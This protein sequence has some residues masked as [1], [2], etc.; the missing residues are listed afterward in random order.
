LTSTLRQLEK[1]YQRYLEADEDRLEPIQTINQLD[2]KVNRS[3]IVDALANL[4]VKRYEGMEETDVRFLTLQEPEEEDFPAW[5]TSYN[6]G[7]DTLVV[8]PVGVFR[9]CE[10]CGEASAAAVLGEKLRDE[11]NFA[12]H[13]YESY[14]AELSKLPAQMLMLLLVL[15]EVANTRQITKVEKK[16]GEIEFPS[17]EGYLNLLW[18]FK[19]L[20]EFYDE[21][22]GIDLRAQYSIFW[23]ESDWV[24]GKKKKKKR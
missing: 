18:A 16:S 4:F 1:A 3:R 20:E 10:E 5:A 17:D 11:A 13:R 14:L 6:D 22:S 21:S 15:Q 19:E 23:Y 9:F 7:E 12:H 2:Q 24:E 8:N